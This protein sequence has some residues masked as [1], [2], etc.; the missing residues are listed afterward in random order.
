MH[1]SGYARHRQPIKITGTR[2][3]NQA[4]QVFLNDSEKR[5]Q[6][7]LSNADSLALLI[8]RL[9]AELHP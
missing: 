6:I 9:G 2:D 4:R 3:L 5:A 7:M 1:R 8:Y